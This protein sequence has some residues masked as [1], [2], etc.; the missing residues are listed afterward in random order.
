MSDNV[1]NLM[2]DILKSIQQSISEL[3]A[4]V[5]G[6]LSAMDNRM[7]AIEDLVRKQRRDT[8]GILVMMKGVVGVFEERVTSLETRV[9]LV[10]MNREKN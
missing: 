5:D 2:F 10:E 8:A 1:Q 6:R 3:D 9:T 4:R 7:S